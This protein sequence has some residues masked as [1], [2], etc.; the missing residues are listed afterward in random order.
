MILRN[1]I[2]KVRGEECVCVWEVAVGGGTVGVER[3]L[4]D[5]RVF[6]RAISGCLLML[7]LFYISK[8]GR[9]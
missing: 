8:Q 2:H 1:L 5:G 3:V 4:V 9:G 7:F 6:A